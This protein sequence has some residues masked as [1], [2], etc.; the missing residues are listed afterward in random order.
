MTK[1]LN[2]LGKLMERPV[3]VFFEVE[4]STE[5][6]C[7][8]SAPGCCSAS[9]SA[10]EGVVEADPPES[11]VPD[12]DG[13]SNPLKADGSTGGRYTKVPDNAERGAGD[14]STEVALLFC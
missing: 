11:W 7:G 12:P 6:V 13:E 10:S 9:D 1:S 8:P 14:L 2:L 5:E 3:L 4:A